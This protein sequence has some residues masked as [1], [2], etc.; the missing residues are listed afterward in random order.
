MKKGKFWKNWKTSI[1]GI[2]GAAPQIITSIDTHNN[3]TLITGICTL[4][5]GLFAKD[6]DVSGENHNHNQ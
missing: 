4:L 5:M 2:I 1:L 3:T 6:Y